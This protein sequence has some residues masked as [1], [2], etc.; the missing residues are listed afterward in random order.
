MKDSFFY[1]FKKFNENKTVIKIK[2]RLKSHTVWGGI[3][4]Q[5][6]III[7]LVNPDIENNFKI[8]TTALLEIITLVGLIN[9]PADR[10]EL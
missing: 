3:I 5:L 8:I 9:N 10:G 4:A 7:A 1:W 2:D 6:C